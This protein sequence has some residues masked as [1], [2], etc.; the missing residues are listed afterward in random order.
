MQSCTDIEPLIGLLIDG[1]LDASAQQ[2]VRA[3]LATCDACRGIATDMQRLRAS[4]QV[5][6]PIDP[7]AHVWRQIVDRIHVEPSA[8]A[9]AVATPPRETALWQ[10]IGLAAALVLVTIGLYLFQGVRPPLSTVADNATPSAVVEPS[11]ANPDDDVKL[12][13]APY[14]KAIA[15]LEVAARN[16]HDSMDTAVASVMQ[17]NIGAIDRAI[18]E[19]QVAVETDPDNEPARDSRVEA[20]RRKVAMLQATVTL[21]NEMRVGDQNGAAAAAESLGRKS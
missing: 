15:E 3:H 21:I 9:R 13:R 1:D 11:V 10:W 14:D 2:N 7:P 4:A 6:G 19:S 17:D 5:L 18:K 16:G 20:L 12:A 8:D